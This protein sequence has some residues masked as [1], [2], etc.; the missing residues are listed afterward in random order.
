MPEHRTDVALI[1]YACRL[2]GAADASAF[3]S[4]L[5]AGRCAVTEVPADRFPRDRYY[6]PDRSV[7][8]KSYTF[9]A[10][11]LDDVF[12]FDPGFFGIS[13]REAIQ[14]DPQQ[15]LL[16]QVVHEAI[17]QAGIRP[18]RLAGSSAGVFVG[19]SSWDYSTRFTADP[20]AVD[21][22]MMTGNTLSI[23]ANRISYIFDLRGP[24]F[25]VDTACSSSLV[26]LHEA[27]E[28]IRSGRIDTAIV[29]GVNVLGSVGPFIGFARASMLSPSGLCRAFD[30]AGDGYVRSE[31]AVAI[32]LKSAAKARADRDRIHALV[33][34]SGI[35]A[36]GRTVGLS[37]PSSE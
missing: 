31:G 37:L 21:V 28:A 25:T 1:G 2:P 29:G 14:M 13:P 4:L 22:Q 7:P 32:V 35:N 26:A 5:E 16:L 34:G 10:G 24:S 20:A 8:G 33:V 23:V 6:H 3:W 27:V 12:G 19:A 15:R 9:K 17:E 30:A 36:D 18:S 11:V